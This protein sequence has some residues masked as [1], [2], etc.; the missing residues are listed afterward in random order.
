MN[1]GAWK[2]SAIIGTSSSS[3]ADSRRTMPSS[4]PT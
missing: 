1:N 4:L 3:V 2:T